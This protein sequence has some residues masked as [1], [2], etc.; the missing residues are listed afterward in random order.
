MRKKFKRIIMVEGCDG[1]GK[2]TLCRRAVEE[3]GYDFVKF[4][5]VYPAWENMTPRE[6]IDFHLTD[7]HRTLVEWPESGVTL[8]CDRSYISTLVYQC[9]EGWFPSKDFR[10][11]LD[12][13]LDIFS[14]FTDELCLVIVAADIPIMHERLQKRSQELVTGNK[15]TLDG[16]D[17]EALEKK[18]ADLHMRYRTCLGYHLIPDIDNRLYLDTSSAS[19]EETFE[20]F[21]FWFEDND[22][23]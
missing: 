18:L 17:S 20:A 1:T 7:F 19:A 6:A 8:L 14:Q 21:K 10:E 13:A 11:V 4:P 2:S 15:D 23:W 12:L 22:E 5:T 9:F 3:F 16:L